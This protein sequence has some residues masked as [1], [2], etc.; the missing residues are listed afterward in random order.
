MGN[1][2]SVFTTEPNK[3]NICVVSFLKTQNAKSTRAS[4][5]LPRDYESAHK[6]MLPT[7]SLYLLEYA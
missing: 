1:R 5:L 3:G 6:V 4:N 7:F 2:I